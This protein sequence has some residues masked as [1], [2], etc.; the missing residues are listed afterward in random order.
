LKF[1]QKKN[2]NIIFIRQ[3][4]PTLTERMQQ[5]LM[6]KFAESTQTMAGLNDNQWLQ[7]S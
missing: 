7:A 3:W 5:A 1:E 2:L 6:K 4:P